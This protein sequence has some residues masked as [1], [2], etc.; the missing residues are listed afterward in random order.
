MRKPTPYETSL[1]PGTLSR[2]AYDWMF[3]IYRAM[4]PNRNGYSPSHQLLS[5]MRRVHQTTFLRRPLPADIHMML[6]D[7]ISVLSRLEDILRDENL[8]LNDH[9]VAKDGR[10]AWKAAYERIGEIMYRDPGCLP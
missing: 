2:E 4:D 7:F 5:Q 1:A 9:T 3:K 8:W 10:A 6:L